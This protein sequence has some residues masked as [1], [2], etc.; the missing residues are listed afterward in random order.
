MSFSRKKGTK[1]KKNQ[2]K[3]QHDKWQLRLNT[4][5]NSSILVVYFIFA[6]C[7]SYYLVTK[8]IPLFPTWDCSDIWQSN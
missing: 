8:E 5:K 6:Y 7:L 3:N 2:Q 4:T 1:K